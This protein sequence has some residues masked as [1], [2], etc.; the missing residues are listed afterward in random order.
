L[1]ATVR[2]L[3]FCRISSSASSVTCTLVEDL[4]KSLTARIAPA[5]FSGRVDSVFV[6]RLYASEKQRI[7]I[8]ITYKLG[9]RKNNANGGGAK[10]N[11][12]LG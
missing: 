11:D 1:A 6:A 5:R 3:A 10:I 7:L 9:A 8:A 2:S 12:V 4:E